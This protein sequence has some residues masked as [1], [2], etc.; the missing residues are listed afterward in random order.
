[1][2]AQRNQS[3]GALLTQAFHPPSAEDQFS[4]N[5]LEEQQQQQQYNQEQLEEIQQLN[6][7]NLIQRIHMTDNNNFPFQAFEN[8]AMLGSSLPSDWAQIYG[9]DEMNGFVDGTGF[10]DNS[11]FVNGLISQNFVDDPWLAQSTEQQ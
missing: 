4:Q 11:V 1:M 7:S 10:G 6:P 9:S 5:F 8:N 2:Y 3:S